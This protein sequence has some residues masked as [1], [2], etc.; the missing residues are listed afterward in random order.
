M[1]NWFWQPTYNQVLRFR[2]SIF[3][4]FRNIKRLAPS[5]SPAVRRLHATGNSRSHCTW[6]HCHS[7]CQS[8]IVS[9]R[10][11]RKIEKFPN[12]NM[13][14]TREFFAVHSVVCKVLVISSYE[15]GHRL[16]SMTLLN[17]LSLAFFD[18]S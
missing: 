17:A 12:R 7:H 8:R 10:L 18:V 15:P 1:R 5:Y 13:K 3:K 4:T 6:C 16:L 9:H 2:S 14:M 11:K